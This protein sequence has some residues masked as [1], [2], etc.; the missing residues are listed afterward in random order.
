MHNTRTR[1]RAHAQAHARVAFQQGKNVL[2]VLD[3]LAG[4]CP[5]GVH[6][7]SAAAHRVT[8]E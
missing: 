7:A 8:L 2:D 1:A 3:V 6:A 4:T 5:V